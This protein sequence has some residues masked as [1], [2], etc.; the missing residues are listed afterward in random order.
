M[1]TLLGQ[2]T[3]GRSGAAPRALA[4][5]DPVYQ[6]ERVSTGPESRVGLLRDDVYA[7]LDTAS[8][9]AVD[10]TP[11]EALTRAGVDARK[12]LSADE[13]AT[14]LSRYGPN[15]FTE[16]QVEPRWKR[17]L[18]QYEGKTLADPIRLNRDIQGVTG[19]TVSSRSMNATVRK[20]LALISAYRAEEFEP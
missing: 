8:T 5:G 12:G 7:Q 3:A 17:F 15:K 18:R 10:L 9:V 13:A 19:A 11:E 1:E 6:G 16:A 14:R 20:A 4:C 2:A